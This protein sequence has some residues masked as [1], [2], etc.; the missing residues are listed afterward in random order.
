MKTCSKRQHPLSFQFPGSGMWL[1]RWCSFV[2]LEETIRCKYARP[3]SA[4]QDGEGAPVSV[5]S[6]I[7]SAGWG[8]S[9]LSCIDRPCWVP[10]I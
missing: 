9:S 1:G 3:A 8:F 10:K 5:G 2:S 6:L 4:G 7:F